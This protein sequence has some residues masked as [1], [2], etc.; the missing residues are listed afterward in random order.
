MLLE[1]INDSKVRPLTYHKKVGCV[2]LCCSSFLGVVTADAFVQEV[3][4]GLLWQARWLSGLHRG[5]GAVLQ[6]HKA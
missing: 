2:G 1:H 5:N 3:A 4:A 6:E